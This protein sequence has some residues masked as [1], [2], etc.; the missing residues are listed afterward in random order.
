MVVI[1][2]VC[3]SRYLL[4]QFF[5]AMSDLEALFLICFK[6]LTDIILL[7][8]SNLYIYILRFLYFCYYYYNF[9]TLSRLN[10]RKN[11]KN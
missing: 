6:Y 8:E 1:L 9:A 11:S 3:F 5:W 7:S 4:I 2:N 10:F